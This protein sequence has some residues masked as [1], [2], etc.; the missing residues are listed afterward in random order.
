MTAQELIA[1]AEKLQSMDVYDAARELN[2]FEYDCRKA[3][4]DDYVKRLKG[5]TESDSI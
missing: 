2:I 3:A 5:G 4:L 1:L